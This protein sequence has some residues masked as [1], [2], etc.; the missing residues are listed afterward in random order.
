MTNA[1]RVRDYWRRVWS[2]GDVAHARDFFAPHYRENDRDRT[3]DGHA[4]GATAFRDYFPDFR[5]EVVG[6]MDFGAVVVSRVVF[7]G[8]Y[9][10]GWAGVGSA[11]ATVEVSG[12]DVFQFKDDLV[13]EHWHEADHEM[14][15]EQLG[16]N[17][18][19]G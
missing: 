14:M 11:G 7:R 5:A 3:P 8:T 2:E 10:G 6:L 19:P 16:V 17:L 12:I 4:R 9:A 15:W 13:F 1:Q 18:P